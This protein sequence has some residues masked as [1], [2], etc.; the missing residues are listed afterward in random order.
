M[1]QVPPWPMTLKIAGCLP[2]L[3]VAGYTGQEALNEPWRFDVELISREA[4]MDL[5]RLTGRQARL[6][7]AGGHPG[8]SGE[9]T[10]VTQVYAGTCLSHYRLTLG[11]ALGRL[12]GPPRQRAFHHL[13]A[14]QIIERLL[15]EHGFTVQDY[16]FEALQGLYQTRPLC[17]QHRESDLHLLQRLCEEEGLYFRFVDTQLVFSDD[18]CSFAE[19][20]RALPLGPC[21]ASGQA[22]GDLVESLTI[23]SATPEPASPGEL[24]CPA[25]ERCAQADNQPCERQGPDSDLQRRARRLERLRGQTR[26]V[27][28]WSRDAAL[29]CGQVVRVVGHSQPRFNDHW[30][31]TRLRH[32]GRQPEVFE[33]HD[34]YD[35]AA[36]V[37]QLAVPD[38]TQEDDL[39]NYVN[40]FEVIEWT[41]A[42]R[43]QLKH[44]RPPASGVQPATLMGGTPDASGCLPVR[45]DWQLSAPMPPTWPRA[46]LAVERIPVGHRLSEG[47]RVLIAC[48][49]NDPDRPVI[50]ALLAAAG[51]HA[52]PRLWLDGL[53]MSTLPEALQVKAGQS[54]TIR[55]SQELVVEGLAGALKMTGQGIGVQ[56]SHAL[57]LGQQPLQ[58]A[59]KDLRLDTAEYAP[60]RQVWYIVRMA[61]PGL[62]HLSRLNAEDVLFEGRSDENGCLGLTP[63]DRQR[64]AVEYARTPGQLC[65][66]QPGRCVTLY[67]H[68][69]R[70]E[71]QDLHVALLEVG[72]LQP[73]P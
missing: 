24:A 15:G 61:E 7:L 26:Q 18:P 56:G 28:G 72:R 22:L 20:S 30:L 48:L 49:D 33:G 5:A 29:T 8:V 69:H 40:H 57:R 58:A 46:Q 59:L 14:P 6:T 60:G 21:P 23:R 16:R 39:D 70:S 66:L 47:D 2:D 38:T 67:E 54:L 62:E 64:L 32:V 31:V 65:L 11:P 19:R 25:G 68:L 41:H 13:S 50:C 35:I 3:Q 27:Q 36:I 42:F 71:Q 45:F 12:N 63:I 34:P 51:Q 44:P 9:I 52:T 43:P 37:A 4:H 53:E 55:G 73:A 17:M 1:T 10:R